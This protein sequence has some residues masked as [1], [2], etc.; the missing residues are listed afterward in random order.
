VAAN[1]AA[2]PSSGLGSGPAAPGGGGP[3][4]AL[5]A[6]HQRLA[7]AALRCYPEAARRFRTRGEVVVSFCLD[8]AGHARQVTPVASS[9]SALL[10]RAATDCVLPGALPMPGAA[11]CY[12]VPVVFGGP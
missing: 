3:S 1:G 10:D 6:L 12:R 7:A 9:G 8:P 4:P 11:G 5:A 2:G